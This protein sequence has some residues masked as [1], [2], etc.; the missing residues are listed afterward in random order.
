MAPITVAVTACPCLMGSSADTRGNGA[1]PRSGTA[2]IGSNKLIALLAAHRKHFVQAG[3]YPSIDRAVNVGPQGSAV[4][5]AELPPQLENPILL[6]LPSAL[7]KPA[8]LDVGAFA[9]SSDKVSG[10]CRR[11]RRKT[12]W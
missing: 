2:R 10:G 3:C 9:I 5:V 7:P 12:G 4:R 8:G 6:Q 11:S 1:Q